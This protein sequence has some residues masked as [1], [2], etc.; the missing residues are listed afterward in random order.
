MTDAAPEAKVEKTAIQMYQY[1]RDV[2]SWR[3]LNHDALLM[4]GGTGTVV[5][6]DESLFRHKPKVIIPLL[7]IY[8]YY[9]GCL[10]QYKCSTI[11]AVVPHSNKF[12]CLECVIL[13]SLLP[14]GS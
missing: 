14:W 4:L 6:I 12:G 7:I 1:F 11:K 8:T 13:A 9:C 3:L 5:Q 10:C 2:C